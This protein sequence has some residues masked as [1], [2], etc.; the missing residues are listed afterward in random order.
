MHEN[1][2][3]NYQMLQQKKFAEIFD[4]LYLSHLYK[5]NETALFKGRCRRTISG[6]IKGLS[7]M[8]LLIV[9][10]ENGEK[11]LYDVKEIALIR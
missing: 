3:V 9:E 6:K 5:L 1:I 10:R 4:Q 8:G 2:E 7:S 11:H